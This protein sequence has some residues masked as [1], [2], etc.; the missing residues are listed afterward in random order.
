MNNCVFCRN[1]LNEKKIRRGGK[2]CS[3][4]CYIEDRRENKERN[5]N[6]KDGT[7]ITNYGC[8]VA[9]RRRSRFKRNVRDKVY[10]AVKKGTLIKQ[11]CCKCGN[12]KAEA[13]HEDYN[14]PLEIIWLCKQC[15]AALHY[16]TDN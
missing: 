9:Y 1:A 12:E 7:C 6:Y 16:P 10:C 11:P 14:K 13:H 5:P 2:Y 8:Q 4:E 15:H 3:R